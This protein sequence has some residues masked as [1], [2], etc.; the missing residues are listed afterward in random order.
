M[1]AD[2][3]RRYREKRFQEIE[4]MPKI[5]CAC[6]CGTLIAPINKTLKPA[7]FAHGHNDVHA[8]KQAQ[9]RKG[10]TIGP[11]NVNWRGG[12]KSHGSGYVQLLVGREH[13][14]ANRVGYVFA[15]R[16]VMSEAIG[17]PLRT[18]EQVHHINGDRSDN[19]LENLQ[20]LQRYHAPGGAY[21]CCDCGSHNVEPAHLKEG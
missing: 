6:G 21:R 15:H 2:A 8:F 11:L 5:H 13:P 16:L 9:F 10:Q 7:R 4:S 17:R 3:T 19:R 20:L 12:R 14:M 18:D 1:S